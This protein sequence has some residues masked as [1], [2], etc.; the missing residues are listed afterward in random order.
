MS[1]SHTN[2]QS[3]T[4]EQTST[5]KKPKN[6]EKK[7]LSPVY[8][9]PYPQRRVVVSETRRSPIDG[10]TLEEENDETDEDEEDQVRN[11]FS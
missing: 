6:L 7:F 8:P 10:P 4:V 5:T 3:H 2:G 1:V 11:L 9:T